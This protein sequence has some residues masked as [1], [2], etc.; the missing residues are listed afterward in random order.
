MNKNV[1]FVHVDQLQVS[2]TLEQT[3]RE[4]FNLKYVSL[5]PLFRY[6]PILLSIGY[7]TKRET[8]TKL[9]NIDVKLI[10]L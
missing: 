1:E 8:I 7:I 4:Y 2:I 9:P 10:N 5:I 6:K 3:R